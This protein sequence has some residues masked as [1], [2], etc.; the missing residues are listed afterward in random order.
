[1]VHLK[2]GLNEIVHENR[3]AHL[4]DRQ[5]SALDEA[6]NSIVILMCDHFRALARV[7]H[8]LE[9]RMF[10]VFV[11]DLVLNFTIKN[12][13]RGIRIIQFDAFVKGNLVA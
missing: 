12:G 9:D 4:P 1:M 2:D 7:G 5:D 13:P 11:D 6:F 3:V 8:S 10:Y